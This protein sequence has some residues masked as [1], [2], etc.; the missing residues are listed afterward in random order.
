MFNVQRLELFATNRNA[1]LRVSLT[2]IYNIL[3]YIVYNTYTNKA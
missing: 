2:H 1:N 3:T